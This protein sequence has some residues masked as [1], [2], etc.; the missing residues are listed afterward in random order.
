MREAKAPSLEGEEIDHLPLAL[1][2]S[3][4]V[5]GM[6]GKGDGTRVK[7]NELELLLAWMGLLAAISWRLDVRIPAQ[8]YSTKGPTERFL[9]VLAPC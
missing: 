3:A 5:R 7:G 8:E 1:S 2:P 9:F 4:T 6:E